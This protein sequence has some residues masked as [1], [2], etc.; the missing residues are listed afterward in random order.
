MRYLLA[1]AVPR[2]AAERPEDSLVISFKPLF[3]PRVRLCEPSFW[4]ELI[5]VNEVMGVA[6]R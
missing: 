2:P 6:K 4:D 1:D 3:V 5:C